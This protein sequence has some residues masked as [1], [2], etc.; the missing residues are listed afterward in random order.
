MTLPNVNWR[1]FWWFVATTTVISA[2]T[3]P[4]VWWR[5]LAVGAIVAWIF[6]TVATPHEYE[7]INEPLSKLV[8]VRHCATCKRY[9]YLDERAYPIAREE[10]RKFNPRNL[11]LQP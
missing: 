4:L 3:A 1:R 10:W 5:S 2:L 11:G 8:R 6:P 9:E 7:W